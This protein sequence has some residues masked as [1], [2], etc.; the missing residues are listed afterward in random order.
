MFVSIPPL[1]CL[2]SKPHNIKPFLQTKLNPKFFLWFFTIDEAACALH[3]FQGMNSAK[4]T[5]NPGTLGGLVQC[6]CWQRNRTVEVLAVLF[7]GNKR[8]TAT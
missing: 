7:W 6:N 5:E 1:P 4:L 8:Q 2:W 3:S